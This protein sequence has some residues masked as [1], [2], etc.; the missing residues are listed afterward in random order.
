[1]LVRKTKEQKEYLLKLKNEI[2]NFL[3]NY[4]KRYQ[5]F[6]WSQVNKVSKLQLNS[7][8][9]V[10]V[11][12]TEFTV[13]EL[14]KEINKTKTKIQ[15]RM[16]PSD[17]NYILRA[18]IK[19]SMNKDKE[20]S[21]M[22]YNEYNEELQKVFKE[23][24]I[25]L[26]FCLEG[27]KQLNKSLKS[28]IVK[29]SVDDNVSYDMINDFNK[30]LNKWKYGV[31]ING[32]KYLK[33]S[34]IDWS[35]Y[36]TIPIK[37]IE[38][39]QV[40]VC[41]D[42]VN[43]QHDWFKKN[44]IK[45]E[46]YFFVMQL[47]DDEDDIVT[48]T[49]SI[50]E[51]ESNKYW[52]ESSWFGH[53]HLMKVNSYKDVI[54]E[55]IKRYD[56]NK[57]NPYSVFKYNPDGMDKNLTN[58]EFFKRAT[59]NCIYDHKGKK[60]I[61]ESVN[62]INQKCYDDFCHYVKWVQHDCDPIFGNIKPLKKYMI[63]NSKKSGDMLLLATY[64]G[65][66]N[67]ENCEKF[68]PN[69]SNNVHYN[70]EKVEFHT[71]YLPG[72]VFI[73]V[74]IPKVV[75][76]AELCK[77]PKYGYKGWHMITDKKEYDREC[78]VEEEENF[79]KTIDDSIIAYIR[80]L[81]SNEKT[82][83]KWHD[84]ISV[85]HYS[86]DPDNFIDGFP[87]PI[88][89]GKITIYFPHEDIMEYD[90]EW[91][92]DLITEATNTDP[93]DRE[94]VL[95][96][97]IKILE[98]NGRKPKVTEKEKTKWI[99]CEPNGFGDA[100]CI[101]GLGNSGLESICTKVNAEI[102]PY[103]E[104]LSPDEYGT[105]FLTIKESEEYKMDTLFLNY[106][107]E[108]EKNILLNCEK[109]ISML[110]YEDISDLEE[111]DELFSEGSNLDLI[112]LYNNE[113]KKA[114]KGLKEAKKLMAKCEY[115]KAIE[116]FKDVK[117]NTKNIKNYVEDGDDTTIEKLIGSFAL[118]WK[119][120]IFDIVGLSSFVIGGGLIQKGVK[121][122]K[123]IPKPIRPIEPILVFDNKFNFETKEWEL[124]KKGLEKLQE[125]N[126]AVINYE[127][128]I[129]DYNKKTAKYFGI[130][131]KVGG[132][133]AGIG[134][135]TNIA[136]IT[137]KLISFAKAYEG[138]KKLLEH[139]M[140]KEHWDRMATKIYNPMRSY[141]YQ[142]CDEIIIICDRCIKKIESSKNDEK[143]LK[144]Y[145]EFDEFK[146]YKFVNENGELE[147]VRDFVL[148]CYESIMLDELEDVDTITEGAN[149]KSRRVYKD[150]KKEVKTLTKQYK[151]YMK[152]EKYDKAKSCL[153]EIK[154]IITQTEKDIR[155]FDSTAG[156]IVFGEIAGSLLGISRYI[157]VLIPIAGPFIV[158]FKNKKYELDKLAQVEDNIKKSDDVTSDS[159][160]KYKN[161]LLSHI[162]SLKQDVKKLESIVSNEE[163]I[164]K[165]I[166]SD[167]VKKEKKR[168][169][170]EE[171]KA[172]KV[173]IYEAC[174]RG[175]ITVEERE[176]LLQNLKDKHYLGEASL[177][178]EGVENDGL[179]NKE[180]FEKVKSVLYERCKNG[181]LTVEERENLIFKAKEMIFT[182]T[183][184]ISKIED[185]K[186]SKPDS[187]D[188]VAKE[189]EKEM[190]KVVK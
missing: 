137:E 186:D 174:Q 19:D 146:T 22:V 95:L 119:Q 112:N 8:L 128:K 167:K 47:S 125:Y 139:D 36:K 129:I 39:Y 159:Y 151:K 60:T 149:L 117:Q 158:Y 82:R 63:H 141:I 49:F 32:K 116:K 62:D 48:H 75:K 135:L 17:Y 35:K 83:P 37:D 77:D 175:E 109:Y 102:K 156:S 14:V 115:K 164:T 25:D 57:E 87:H 73:Y 190:D 161:Y 81:D 90:W 7:Q 110:E 52:F 177:N 142:I 100:L 34:D 106:L 71:C 68:L 148:S 133:F 121:N 31:L 29:E 56:K 20:G 111:D 178:T 172:E 153:N 38:K 171:F 132:I 136:S 76:E 92:E 13:K 66:L 85:F 163:K 50:I 183:E 188:K 21:K 51:F 181:E 179:S 44:N 114:K 41:W 105:T 15:N 42:F 84:K 176:E 144:E 55:L 108:D 67:K 18:Y 9:P 86:A 103:G 88:L 104:K 23:L 189:L 93:D 124:T 173:S 74:K 1:M 98:E 131:K 150:M 160:N 12:E 6:P 33:S 185:I 182:E 43:Y 130:Y 58:S 180:K 26:L 122:L 89:T 162:T 53:Q 187:S 134:I 59:K 2:S 113:V 120:Y 10:K 184:D 78:S 5:L 65:D 166:V 157:Y 97:A 27:L 54:S 169:E 123:K 80:H 138:S 155:S 152:H 24:K 3:V 11:N 96:K 46:S 16:K 69:L 107:T 91:E 61:Q 127:K 30:T 99:N 101:A 28:N 154:K 118:A 79:F 72:D 168:K 170:T 64:N 126:N 145:T 70:D 140:D 45:D 40:G 147:D 94:N 4:K 165:R 143:E